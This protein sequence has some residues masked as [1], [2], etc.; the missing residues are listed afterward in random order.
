MPPISRPAGAPCWIDLITSDIERSK[1]VYGELF[2]W[3]FEDAGADY[4]H[5]NMASKDGAPVAGVMGK[6]DPNQP[7]TWTVY[8]HSDDV[9]ATVDKVEAAGG[10][11]MFP[12][13]AVGTRGSMTVVF[14][15]A[16]AVVG[17]WQPDDFSG[18]EL[19]GAHGTPLWFESLSKSYD[20]SVAFY[21][22]AFDWD[23]HTM[24]DEPDFRYS[25][26]GEGDQARAG[27]MDASGFLD[28]AVPSL[29]QFYLGCDDVD[30]T[31]ARLVDLGGRELNPLHD[32]PF[33]RIGG[34]LDA[35]GALICLS[36]IRS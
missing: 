29:W 25:T 1:A 13:M 32:T 2:G 4:G 26:L 7:D 3:T 14:D 30:A 28:E 27:I 5:Y 12:P 9:A 8:L 17:A 11:L 10:R 21:R 15:P 23:V 20:A 19:I 31:A 34:Y 36:S 24:S 18:F 6:R 35:T 22:D 16:G 33:G